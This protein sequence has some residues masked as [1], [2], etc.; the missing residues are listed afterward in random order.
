MVLHKAVVVNSLIIVMYR[1]Y[2][3]RRAREREHKLLLARAYMI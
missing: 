2:P 3:Q 1:L